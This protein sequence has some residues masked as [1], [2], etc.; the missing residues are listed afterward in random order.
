MDIRPVWKLL[1]VLKLPVKLSILRDIGCFLSN[2]R[3]VCPVYFS[4]LFSFSL[5]VFNTSSSSSIEMDALN[6]ISVVSVGKTLSSRFFKVSLMLLA[7][8]DILK[9]S[10]RLKED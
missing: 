1:I 5:K 4:L 9:L 10:L 8:T 2:G 6:S 3:F 7:C